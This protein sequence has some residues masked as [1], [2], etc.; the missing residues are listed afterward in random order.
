MKAWFGDI[1]QDGSARCS[2]CNLLVGGIYQNKYFHYINQHPHILLT[3]LETQEKK[4]VIVE[5]ADVIKR[6]IALKKKSKRLI[7]R[8]KEEEKKEK[9]VEVV[10]VLE[11]FV[12]EEG[13]EASVEAKKIRDA[14]KIAAKREKMRLENAEEWKLK[15][16]KHTEYERERYSSKREDTGKS[17]VETKSEDGEEDTVIDDGNV[18]K[19][20]NWMR[21]SVRLKDSDGLGEGSV[22]I[23]TTRGVKKYGYVDAKGGL[24][25]KEVVS[26]ILELVSKI[27]MVEPID[28]GLWAKLDQEEECV[29]EFVKVCLF[30]G[31]QLGFG[32]ALGSEVNFMEFF[33][34][35]GLHLDTFLSGVYSMILILE[36]NSPTTE[37]LVDHPPYFGMSVPSEYDLTDPNWIDVVGEFSFLFFW[38]F[39]F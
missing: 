15:K 8:E 32:H 11:M 12:W 23:T 29:K 27:D 21:Q 2:T 19:G 20:L 33:T 24:M 26:A 30:L 22:M 13:I 9:W 36:D 25:R 4:R 31:R 28:G 18:L 10:E 16:K 34:T 14:E 17:N 39:F 37:V 38:I 6:L 7:V 1:S 3:R 5:V 35:Q